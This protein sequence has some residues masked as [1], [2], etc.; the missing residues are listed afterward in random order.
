[1]PEIVTITTPE[2][3]EII[4]L[5]GAAKGADGLNASLLLLE[6]EAG[7]DIPA[8]GWP[9]AIDRATKKGVLARA[10]TYMLSFVIGFSKEAT[11][12]GFICPLEVYAVTL[13]DW[14][15]IAG[16]E[17]LTPGNQYFLQKTTGIGAVD[18]SAAATA[19]VGTALSPTALKL[20]I[21]NPT[22]M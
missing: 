20:S 17:H 18:L 2:T 6:I 12:T 1:M 13:T 19:M 7:E 9:I 21:T 3:V 10:D 4:T 22:L 8:A 5:S 14:T 16:S 15:A 11:L